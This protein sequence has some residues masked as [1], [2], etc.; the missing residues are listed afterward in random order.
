MRS[1]TV[2]QASRVANEHL[3]ELAREDAAGAPAEQ[4]R[5]AQGAKNEIAALRDRVRAIASSESA[6]ANARAAQTAEIERR[7]VNRANADAMNMP[8]LQREL[9]RV[10]VQSEAAEARL[11]QRLQQEVALVRN[12]FHD[13]ERRRGEAQDRAQKLERRLEVAE[14]LLTDNEELRER[15][16]AKDA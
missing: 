12:V 7:A 13:V 6:L 9:Q 14:G 15:A 5:L 4:A 10:E 11:V 3:G 1:L 2:A 8:E 16:K